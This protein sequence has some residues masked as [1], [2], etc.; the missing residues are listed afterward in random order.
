MRTND[1][2]VE[3][4]KEFEGFVSKWY[5]DPAHGWKV[6]T[7]MYGHTDAAGEPKYAKTK[8]RVFTK[9]EGDAAL[10]R[11]LKQY[12]DSVNSSVKVPLTAN[13][14]AALVSFTYN[15]GAG[16]MRSSTLLKKLNSG[17]YAGAADEF[18][19]WNKAGGKVLA[20]LTRRRKAERDLF[21]KSGSVATKPKMTFAEALAALFAALFGSKK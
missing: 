15:L 8:D 2:G 19:K 4:I 13:Q 9:S 17:D 16:N 7:V 3:L 5:P 20:G 14:F 6:P 11:D 1:A 10:R 18:G 12:E 21:L